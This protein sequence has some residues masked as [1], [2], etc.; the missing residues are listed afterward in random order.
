[1]STAL[2]T[3]VLPA[4]RLGACVI[5]FGTLAACASRV[6]QSPDSAR[7]STT[8]F[9]IVRHAEKASDDPK[10]PSLSEAGRVRA[11]RLAAL[12]RDE[13]VVAVYASGY[14]RTQATAAP[15]ATAHGLEVRTYDAAQ[16]AAAFAATLRDDHRRD[17]VLIVGHSNTVS[18]I[19]AALCAC[20]VPPLREDE[21]DRWITVRI[22]AHGTATLRT[23]NY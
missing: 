8:T 15:T 23:R 14:R 6:D 5:V 2:S 4:A 11:Q 12:L 21:F 13:T 16:P 20:E 10:N 19:A 9:H 18:P 1:M 7:A 3:I 17:S 22:D